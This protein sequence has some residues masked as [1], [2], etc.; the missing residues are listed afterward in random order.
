VVLT[1]L[2]NR[3]ADVSIQDV[4]VLITQHAN[5]MTLEANLGKLNALD[6]TPVCYPSR[7]VV[8]LRSHS[9][10]GFLVSGGCSVFARHRNSAFILLQ[11]N[12]DCNHP[13]EAHSCPRPSTKC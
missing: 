13:F 7:F 11:S 2:G 3:L 9:I 6:L 4:S 5:A 10:H 1:A 8:Y 12:S